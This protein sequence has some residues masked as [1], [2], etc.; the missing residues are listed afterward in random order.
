MV[1]ETL[2]YKLGSLHGLLCELADEELYQGEHTIAYTG[3]D[4]IQRTLHAYIEGTDFQMTETP[5]TSDLHLFS[6]V[7]PLDEDDGEG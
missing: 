7:F 2:V 6:E 1:Y 3:R 4:G 5:V